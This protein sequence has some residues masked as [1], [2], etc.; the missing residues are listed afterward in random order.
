MTETQQSPTN[1][2]QSPTNGNPL[3]EASPT[4]LEEYF[5][6]DP[7]GFTKQDLEVVVKELRRMREKWK[8]EEASGATKGKKASA[9]KRP[10]AGSFDDLGI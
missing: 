6:R 5:S 3:E 8:V 10:E 2:Q 1:T 9:Q 7:E 4:S